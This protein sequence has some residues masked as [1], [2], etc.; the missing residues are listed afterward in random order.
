MAR[1]YRSQGD[2]EQLRATYERILEIQ[3]EGRSADAARRALEELR[4]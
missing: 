1:V 2:I 4:R 3:P